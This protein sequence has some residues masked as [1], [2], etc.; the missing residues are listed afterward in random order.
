MTVV[1]GVEGALLLRVLSTFLREDVVGLRTRSVKED[2]PDGLW[3]RRAATDATALLLPAREDGFQ[4]EYAARLPLLR[5]EPEGREVTTGVAVLAEIAA[6]ADPE[7]RAGFDA[8]AAE[9]RDALAALRLQAATHDQVT[10]DLAARLGADCARWAGTSASL[11]FDVLA[12]RTGHPLYP[13]GAARIGL[14][15]DDLR[16]YAPEYAPR[17]ALRWVALSKDVVTVRGVGVGVGVGVGGGLGLDERPGGFWP[18]PSDL[19]LTGLDA[20]HLTLPV[21]PLTAAGP[22]REALRATG[23]A[24]RAVLAE[25]PLPDVTPTLS[26]RTVALTASPDIHLKLPLATS[27]LGLLNR[28][29]IK[30]G[31]L[32]DGAAGQRLLEV[33]AAREPRFRGRILHVDES[34]YAHADHEL[35]AV[36]VRRIPT[37]LGGCTIVPLAALTAPAPGGRLVIDHLADRWFGGDPAAL[38][39][40]LLTLLLDWHV[41]LLGYGIALESHQQNIS[42]VLDEPEP[43]TEAPTRIRLLYKDD[44]SP[45]IH[46][47]RLRAALG[48]D[49]PEPA[50]FADRRIFVDDD[51]PVL[52]LFVTITLHLCAGA[53]AFNLADHGR[54]PLKQ[55]L[56]LVRDRLD[57]AIQRLDDRPGAPDGPGDLQTALRAHTLDAAHLPVKAMVTAGTLLTKARSGASDINKHYTTGPNYLLRRYR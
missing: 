40:A 15:A 49:A 37:G 43:E 4:S 35:L 57:E 34:C 23:L 31:S 25:R 48:P 14:S 55:L 20:T 12:A 11:A 7:D 47:S 41:T 18:S 45:R 2:R 33:V 56:D 8:F 39:D 54:A 16:R 32:V 6:L 21:H 51:G 44:D 29:T 30:P 26:M 24:D 13:T 53:F 42:I 10:A 52:D 28:R 9:Y 1:G 46:H 22:L 36:L 50:E 17:F 27:T 3:L 38:L 5:I 19:G